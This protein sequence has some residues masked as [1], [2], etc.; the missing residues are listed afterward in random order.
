MGGLLAAAARSSAAELDAI[1][2]HQLLPL[3]ALIDEGQ[4]G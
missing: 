2:L 3:R 4:C 1:H